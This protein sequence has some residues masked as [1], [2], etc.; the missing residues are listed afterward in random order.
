LSLATKKEENLRA[1]VLALLVL[2]SGPESR[3][4]LRFTYSWEQGLDDSCGLQALACLLDLYWGD[5]VGEADLVLSLA[6][7]RSGAGR[8]GIAGVSLGDLVFLARGLGYEAEAFELGLEDLGPAL[9]RYPPILVHYDKPRGHFA[10][11]LAAIARPG[12]EGLFV[13]ADPA[14]GLQ[15]LGES[16]FLARWSGYALV[17]ARPGAPAPQSLDAGSL[18]AAIQAGMGPWRLLE[19]SDGRGWRSWP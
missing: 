10:L 12:C 15:V 2:I 5:S 3:E 6:E 18:A 14:S 17:L 13:L 9:A 4:S 8:E 1:F 19:E 16:D 11:V 7:G